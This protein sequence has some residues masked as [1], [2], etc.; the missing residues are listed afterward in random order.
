[1]GKMEVF[2]TNSVEL[3]VSVMVFRAGVATVEAGSI[4][5]AGSVSMLEDKSVSD[6]NS[7]G[8]AVKMFSGAGMVSVW[9]KGLDEELGAIV[10]FSEFVNVL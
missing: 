5:M 1:M 7:S 10:G 2:S 9:N 6:E 4:T 8:K 3:N